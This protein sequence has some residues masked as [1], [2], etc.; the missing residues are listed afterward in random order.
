MPYIKGEDRRQVILFKD[1]LDDLVDKDNPVRGIDAFVQMLDMASLGFLKAHTE[2]VGR[3][4]YDPRDLL[5]LYIYGYLNGIRSSRKLETETKRNIELMW[6][7]SKLKPDFKTIA[8]FRK[9]NK[10]SLFNV[11]RRFNAL[12]KD[13]G[14]YSETLIAVDGTK[15]KA[16]NSKKNNFNKKKIKRHLAYIDERIDEYMNALDKADEAESELSV[17]DAA[18]LMRRV[19]EYQERKQEY[20]SM[21]DKMEVQ[22][23]N[24]VSITDPDARSMAVNNKG[25]DVCYN[26][27]TV[28]DSKHSLIADCEVTNNPTDHGQ[29]SIMGKRAKE[30]F[31]TEELEVLADKGYY[32]TNDLIECEKANLKT[33]V[34]KPNNKDNLKDEEYRLDKFQYDAAKDLY[35]CPTGHELYPGQIRK[36]NEVKYQDYKNYR[37][38]RKCESRDRCTKSQRGRVISR[39]LNQSLL[40]EVDRRTQD[41]KDL[42]R[43]RQTIVE[44]PF[45]VIKRQW[46]FGYF[47]TRGLDS[48]KAETSLMFL[49]YNIRRVI[50]ILGIEAMKTRLSYA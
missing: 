1:C 24:E 31:Q 29:L 10:E 7:M 39:N 20:N 2:P 12:C 37:A 30:V 49:A 6:L 5:K 50:N 34:A 43:M 36:I 44:H 33:Y 45:G 23:I 3:H 42:Y 4:P 15:I 19:A 11:F 32:S 40:D 48:V 9:D 14:L 25:I 38:C 16:Y 17:P 41:N 13:W 35:I 47:L 46:G 21:L 22:G 26:V 28:V 18:E 27:Q 8:D